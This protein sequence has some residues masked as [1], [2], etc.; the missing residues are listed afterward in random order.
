MVEKKL[1]EQIERDFEMF[2]DKVLAI[3]L[4]GSLV[5]NEQTAGSDIDVCLVVGSKDVKEVFNLVLESGLTTKYD[6][7]IFEMLP[8]KLK[9][10]II[11]NHKVVWTKDAGELS[12]YLYKHRKV[13]DDQK[14]ALKKLGLEM[15]G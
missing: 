9:G 14:L 13:W 6:I 10:E 12:Y 7:K 5:K 3:L 11:E 4:F 15:F 2:K 1:I 8:L